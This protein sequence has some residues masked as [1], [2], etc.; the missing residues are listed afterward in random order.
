[1]VGE[2][3]DLS[4][5][6]MN[7]QEAFTCLLYPPKGASTKV[8]D[9]RYTLF[10]SKKGEIESHQLP[11]CRDCLEKH[12]QRANFQAAVWKRC[13]EQD[14]NVPSP[15]R[16]GWKMEREEGTAEKCTLPKCE[17]IAN[18]LKCTEMCKL[19]HCENQVTLESEESEDEEVDGEDLDEEEDEYGKEEDEY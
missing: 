11:P 5:E 8:N 12:G 9:L 18:G 10:C 17:C 2:Q 6:L 14:P 1:M 16:R 15:I 7:E 19:K 3:W 13:L 4:P